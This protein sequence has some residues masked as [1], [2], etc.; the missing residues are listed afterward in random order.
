MKFLKELIEIALRDDWDTDLVSS[1]LRRLLSRKRLVSKATYW[2]QRLCRLDTMAAEML[3]T[4]GAGALLAKANAVN[5]A[6]NELSEALD[7]AS[8]ETNTETNTVRC[9]ADAKWITSGEWK[10]YK[11]PTGVEDQFEY[12]GAIQRNEDM[13]GWCR[14]TS[15]VHAWDPQPGMPTDTLEQAKAKVEEGWEPVA[16]SN[17]MCCQ[18]EAKW[19]KSSCDYPTKE[20][21]QVPTGAAARVEYLGTIEQNGNGGMWDWCRRDSEE[22]EWVA[23]SGFEDTRAQAKAKVLEGWEPVAE[24]NTEPVV[25]PVAEPVAETNTVRCRAEARWKTTDR[26]TAGSVREIYQVPTGVGSA[27]EYLGTARPNGTWI[28][29]KSGV[30]EWV[31]GDGTEDTLEKAKAKVLEGWETGA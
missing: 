7:Q 23:G 8:G 12:L 21:Y 30:H 9:R 18:A 15:A 19:V 28:R 6:I 3:A 4:P 1:N 20:L 11:V 17:T 27:F 10:L 2:R 31:V 14:N 22:H 13:W 26:L 29:Y 16:W 24:T 5:I 25:E